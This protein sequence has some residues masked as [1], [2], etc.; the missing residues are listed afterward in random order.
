[1]VEVKMFDYIDTATGGVMNRNHVMKISDFKPTKDENYISLFRFNKLYIDYFTQK[2]T[3]AGF[4][5][6]HYS[7]YLTFDVDNESLDQAWIDTTWLCDLILIKTG[8]RIN[9]LYFSGAKGF[10]V[11]IPIS[12]FKLP[13]SDNFCLLCKELAKNISFNGKKYLCDLKIYEINRLFRVNNTINKKSGL[14]KI[15]LSWNEFDKKIPFIRELARD[16]R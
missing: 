6:V 14:Y 7:D 10:H 15:K 16:P 13:P 2:K 12:L 9:E 5:G 1:M 8:Y 4:K 3:V 11:E